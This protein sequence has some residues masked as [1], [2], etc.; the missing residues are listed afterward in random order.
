MIALPLRTLLVLPFRKVKS[1]LI[2]IRTWLEVVCTDSMSRA[3]TRSTK[4]D[5]REYACNP[6]PCPHDQR[7]GHSA[8]FLPG[9]PFWNPFMISVQRP[10]QNIHTRAR[11]YLRILICEHSYRLRLRPMAHSTYGTGNV[12]Y[13][14]IEFLRLMHAQLH[15]P[16]L[17]S[18]TGKTRLH[19]CSM[20]RRS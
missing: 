10:K 6:E 4:K 18:R 7:I 11:T 5:S 8:R 17:L 20:L 19:I 2:T 14:L 1:R 13:S 16:T 12:L 9:W 15:R 3:V